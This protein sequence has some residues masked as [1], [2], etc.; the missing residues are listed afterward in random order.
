MRDNITKTDPKQFKH[1]GNMTCCCSSLHA[2]LIFSSDAL[3]FIISSVARKHKWRL[4][5]TCVMIYLRKSVFHF[6]VCRISLFID[7]PPTFF[8]PQPS[9]EKKTFAS[10]ICSNYQCFLTQRAMKV[11]PTERLNYGKR[12]DMSS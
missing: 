8:Q 1:D 6:A 3:F 12:Y 10:D 4:Q 2:D 9:L 11:R 7:T 5:V